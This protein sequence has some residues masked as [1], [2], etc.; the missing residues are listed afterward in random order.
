MLFLMWWKLASIYLSP[1]VT[2]LLS[3]LCS[4]T[5]NS[6]IIMPTF[7]HQP[8]WMCFLYPSILGHLSLPQSTKNKKMLIVT[9]YRINAT[10]FIIVMSL[11]F[12]LWLYI[13]Q[14]WLLIV[15]L[16]FLILNF[17]SQL[18][19]YLFYFAGTV[20]GFHTTS[21]IFISCNWGG[22]CCRAAKPLLN[23][24]RWNSNRWSWK[25]SS[26]ISHFFSPGS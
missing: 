4:A 7:Y 5:V 26:I 15:W 11:Y 24:I 25:N 10:L 6:D 2:N 8:H 20:M 9:L 23:T 12:K 18:T 16:F 3:N 22:P 21:C 17:I 13:S 14:L 1:F 19:V